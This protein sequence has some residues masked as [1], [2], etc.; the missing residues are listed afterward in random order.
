MR[1]LPK[2]WERNT[3]TSNTGMTPG[4]LWRV[5]NFMPNILEPK[6]YFHWWEK[7]YNL[8]FLLII[9]SVCNSKFYS[10]FRHD[11]WHSIVFHL[12]VFVSWVHL[13]SV[14][15]AKMSPHGQTSCI[16][17]YHRIVLSHAPK[18]LSFGLKGCMLGKT[19][20]VIHMTRHLHKLLW[21]VHYGIPM[22]ENVYERILI[23]AHTF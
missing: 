3:K 23:I 12:S 16:K 4:M 6:Y 8:K 14:A 19:R 1:A 5:S 17:S 10:I 22:S 20:H 9:L 13:K 15:I 11:S 7:R 18:H 21:I 2:W